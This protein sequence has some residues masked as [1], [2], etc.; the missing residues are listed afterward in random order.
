MKRFIQKENRKLLPTAEDLYVVQG[1]PVQEIADILK[2][3][4]TTLYR[5]SER[6]GWKDK[7]AMH[8]NVFRNTLI[9]LERKLEQVTTD[10]DKLNLADEQFTSKCDAISKLLGQIVKLRNHY[11]QDQL[12]ATVDIMSSF[13]TYVRRLDL[14]E[15]KVEVIELAMN[16]FFSEQRKKSA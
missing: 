5:W 2:I 15:E 7:R 10:L 16:G 14:P 8:Q 12:K 1:K 3:S 6:E 13:A 11:D 9:T 4:T